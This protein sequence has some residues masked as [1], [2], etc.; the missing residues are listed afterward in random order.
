MSV[1][2]GCCIVQNRVMVRVDAQ[3]LY[4]DSLILYPFVKETFDDVLSEDWRL[5]VFYLVWISDQPIRE[6]CFPRE[7]KRE[8]SSLVIV[9]HFISC[10]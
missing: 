7:A 9:E 5:E 3:L 10:Q 1:G 6:Y 8:L 4:D 2:L